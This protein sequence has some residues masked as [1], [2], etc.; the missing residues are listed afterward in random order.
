MNRIRELR[1][2]KGWRQEDLAVRL[3]KNRQSVGN[4]E[5][6]TRGIDVETICALC[7]IFGCTADYLL[8]RSN[9]PTSNLTPEEENLLLAWRRCDDRARDMVL[10]ALAPFASGQSQTEAG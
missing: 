1:E 5:T 10:V 3:H 4:Y 8:C 9:T 6:G 2:Q 7:D